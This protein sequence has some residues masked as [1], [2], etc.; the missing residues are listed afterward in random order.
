VAVPGA[1]PSVPA[2]SCAYAAT[3]CTDHHSSHG[4]LTRAQ[5]PKYQKL[6]AVLY[7]EDYGG[8]DEVIQFSCTSSFPF[9]SIDACVGNASF[10]LEPAGTAARQCSD[11]VSLLWHRFQWV[12][13]MPACVLRMPL[14]HE[15]NFLCKSDVYGWTGQTY[16]RRVLSFHSCICAT[17]APD[18]GRLCAL[19]YT[20]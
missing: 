10:G 7:D 9:N 16:L 6:T 20:L 5:V 8:D 18:S 14:L 3:L 1:V 13:C 19:V 17:S 12:H 15:P 4:G 11:A 2:A